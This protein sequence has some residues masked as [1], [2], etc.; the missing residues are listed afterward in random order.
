[1]I[2]SMTGYGKGL[3]RDGE[4]VIEVE[5]KTFN[6]RF[7]DVNLKLP[8][9]ILDKEF[10]IRNKLRNKLKR[11]KVSLSV[12]LKRE[13]SDGKAVFIDPEGLNT[14]INLLHKISEKSGLK[15]SKMRIEDILNFQHLFLTDSVM[16]SEKEFQLVD[17]A[18]EIALEQVII[19]REKEGK[20]LEKDLKMRIERIEKI[21]N[22]ISLIRRNTVE[23]YFEKL[24]ER[25]AQLLVELVDNQDRLNLELSLIAEKCDVT[26]ECVRLNSHIK[27]FLDT[28]S[29]SDESGK[30]LNF[31]LQEMNRE[32]NT[33]NSKTISADISHLGITIKEELE[34]IREQ[35]QNIE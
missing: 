26:E 9:S 17:K 3:V 25:A 28:L 8:K 18:I 20:E 13:G 30:K 16:D 11:G 27:L 35:I 6:N 15:K 10:E 22:K 7:Q 34:K 23:E 4:V 33:I 5:I 1:M 12:F 24:K 14:T 21:I 19:M 2:K 29:D 32:A 31:I